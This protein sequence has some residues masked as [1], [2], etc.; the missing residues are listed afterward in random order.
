ME[1]C[2]NKPNVEK[3]SSSHARGNLK[4][5]NQDG[6]S[7]WKQGA[8]FGCRGETSTNVSKAPEGRFRTPAGGRDPNTCS[9]CY[10]QP[11]ANVDKQSF[12]NKGEHKKTTKM[13]GSI[14][15]RRW[16][17][18]YGGETSIDVFEA[19]VGRFETP[20]G[21][22]DPDV[23][24]RLPYTRGNIKWTSKD[25]GKCLMMMW[26]VWQSEWA[27]YEGTE[28]PVG[29]QDSHWEEKDLLLV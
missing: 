16:S 9:V 25:E 5:N 22:R 10:N 7:L 17:S 2:E 29:V 8:S 12:S 3:W 21:G 11:N 14:Q 1:W 26:G 23:T 6:G 4:T 27:F 19:L 20:A 28:P 24:I 15:K 18:G 13:R